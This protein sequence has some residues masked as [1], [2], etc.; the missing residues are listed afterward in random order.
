MIYRPTF[1]TDHDDD[2]FPQPEPWEPIEIVAD[3]VVRGVAMR[4]KQPQS[5]TPKRVND[6]VDPEGD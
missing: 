6:A 1:L 2:D 4:R 5:A 3:R